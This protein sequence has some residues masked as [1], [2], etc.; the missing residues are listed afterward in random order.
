MWPW[1]IR[2][3]NF[4]EKSSDGMWESIC[5]CGND[6][7][8]LAALCF[9]NTWVKVHTEK[10]TNVRGGENAKAGKHSDCGLLSSVSSSGSESK[11]W[12]WARQK[13]SSVVRR[14]ASAASFTLRG[15]RFKDSWD[16]Y[17]YQR[18]EARPELY[19]GTVKVFG[20][21]DLTCH[22]LLVQMHI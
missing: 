18:P 8:S 19:T 12:S 16:G 22:R 5:L 9:L 21:Q 2:W 14:R 20:G 15:G 7:K 1:R 10:W 6:I 4:R 11:Q 3:E 17:T 13:T